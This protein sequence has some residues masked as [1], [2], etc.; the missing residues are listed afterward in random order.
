MKTKIESN[1][2]PDYTFENF[3]GGD[4]NRLA[5]AAGYEIAKDPGGTA[6]NP[7]FLHSPT[8]LGKTHLMHAIGNQ[9]KKKYPGE[10]VV[11]VSAEELTQQ[12]IEYSKNSNKNGF[13][14]LYQSVDVLLVDDVHI[15][16]GRSGT[17]ACL[18]QI[19]NDMRRKGK[20]IVFSSDKSPIELEGIEG[21][22][23]TRF[24]W[25]LCADLEIPDLETRIEILKS[26][27][28][29]LDEINIPNEVIECI[30]QNVSTNIFE[31]EGALNTILALATLNKRKITIDLVRDVLKIQEV[32]ELQPQALD[33]E[34]VVLGAIMLE[35]EALKVLDIL[36][37][38]FFYK[39][40]NRIIFDVIHELF[41]NAQPVDILTVTNKL[42]ELGKLDEVG[43]A[44]YISIL[45]NRVS[46]TENIEVYARIIVDNFMRRELIKVSESI[47][48]NAKDETMD[49]LDVFE[50]ADRD[51]IT[52][53]E[54]CLNTDYSN[55][56]TLVDAVI[57]ET[58][59]AYSNE[60]GISDNAI[61]SSF[62]ALD[63][64]TNGFRKSTLTVIAAR[65]A[66]GKTAFALSM[67][68]HIAIE[69]GLPIAF[70]SL[71][72]SNMELVRRMVSSE[73]EINTQK[74]KTG[75]LEK[76]ELD[77]LAE[78]T[79]LLSKAP[80]FID[81]SASLNMAELR[82]KCRRL[83]QKHGIKIVFVD[84]LQLIQES[85]DLCG[86][87]DEQIKEIMLKLKALSKELNLPII[88]MSQISRD[89]KLSKDKRPQLSDLR[90]PSVAEQEADMVILIHRPE[91]YGISK[92]E[93]DC[94]LG[95]AEIIVEKNRDGATGKALL[96]LNKEF[97]K[98]ENLDYDE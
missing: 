47:S 59:S 52:I 37:S 27:I 10:I 6:F 89:V 21:R 73:T 84:Y 3:I 7:L 72:M 81:D 48:K 54:R 69:Q 65:P 64:I 14:E 80:I 33:M 79:E 28:N 40:E 93:Y 56:K 82:A 78:K 92:N 60:D 42:R 4:C 83:I 29:K 19:F 62:L 68:R 95:K 91:Y 9:I 97:V 36:T 63:R 16:S 94:M 86:N 22:L 11:Y 61:A 26:K 8:G 96:K 46:S 70:F 12:Y 15:L 2:N 66:M 44:Y 76:H 31:L 23:L 58:K 35:Q 1:L 50:Y 34:E 87:R 25:G 17:Q 55:M 67:M 71:E 41:C 49:V 77:Q 53:G 75:N 24:K 45:T 90:I 88:V 39:F 32:E 5:R 98:F 13:I 43:G 51:L 85:S 30:A 20:Q 38:N 74:I 18:F 57:E